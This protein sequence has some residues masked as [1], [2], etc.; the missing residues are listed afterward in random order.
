MAHQPPGDVRP[1][2]AQSNNTDLHPAALRSS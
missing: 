1:H 2:A